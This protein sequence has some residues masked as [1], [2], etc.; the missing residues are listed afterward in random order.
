MI[1]RTDYCNSLLFK[2]P[3]VHVKNLQ[4]VQ[5][6]A[7]CLVSS[8]PSRIDHITGTVY[9]LHWLPVAFRTKLKLLILF[10]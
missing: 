7:G 3:A 1:G 9:R 8:I 6:C 10:F 2:I 5:N 4:R